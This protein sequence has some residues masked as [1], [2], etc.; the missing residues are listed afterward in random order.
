VRRAIGG[1]FRFVDLP[2]DDPAV[3][4]LLREGDGVGVFQLGTTGIR[5]AIGKVGVS[6]FEDLVAINALYR[7]GT[8]RTGI[9]DDYADRKAGRQPVE[10]IHPIYDE[11]TKA[12]YGLI[13]YQ[14]QVMWLLSRL[15]GFPWEKTDRVRKIISKSKG[16]RQFQRY[17]REFVTGCVERG[18]L[19]GDTARTLYQRLRQFSQYAFNRS[20]SVGYTMLGY[21]TAWCKA[22]HRREFMAALL[23]HTGS[24]DKV[25]GY[26]NDARY[27]GI[28]VVDPHV[29]ASGVSWEIRDGRLVA[30]LTTVKGIAAAS[31]E[32]IVRV[33]GGKPFSGSLDFEMR[34]QGTGR[35]V[36]EALGRAGALEG[37]AEC[38]I[39][40]AAALPYT[41][42]GAY[43][44]LKLFLR[45]NAPRQRLG[46][47]AIERMASGN[48]GGVAFD[49]L[50]IRKLGDAEMEVLRAP[51]L[52]C[53][54]CPL[55][56]EASTPVPL[57]GGT[58][59][60]MIVCEAPGKVEDREGRPLVGPAGRLL[61]EQME[62]A[63]LR[64]E[65][66]YLANAVRCWPS[67]S[68]R[69]SMKQVDECSKHL[70][71][72]MERVQP[73]LVLAAGN[74]A[75]Y[76]FTGEKA[77]IMS[78]NAELAWSERYGCFVLFTIH[79]S[80]VLRDKGNAPMLREAIGRLH[81]LI[82]AMSGKGGAG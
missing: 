70:R 62:A 50:R 31:A 44:R 66:F 19:D 74:M 7:P 32:R 36:L 69:P 81:G 77:G 73:C 41:A 43:P 15:A 14:E 47:G 78:H 9:L 30:G 71:A 11:I 53:R 58:L 21:W 27:H 51:V 48:I 60:V 56:K 63:G 67:K 17:E 61:F 49:A 22:H 46:E 59:N 29:N 37:L 72:E 68:G 65:Y 4:R 55:R 45:R 75:R 28:E 57:E 1:G 40:R 13:V 38:E 54:A 79:P 3:F 34:S 42:R 39:D 24:D 5:S 8:L 76:A 52:A 82:F 33:R 6:S 26:V 12:T 2:L 35:S 64:R 18:T 80:A 20:H 23:R 16:V 10:R 25:A